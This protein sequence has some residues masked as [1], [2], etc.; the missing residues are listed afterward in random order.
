MK[1]DLQINSKCPLISC[2]MPT[3]GRP[4]Y[5]PEAVA[6]FLQQDY[7]NKELI[8]LNDCPGQTYTGDQPGVR[9]VNVPDRF[10]T[11]GE[12]RNASIE[13]AQGE[14]IAVWDD[15]DISLPWRLSLS[16][17]EMVR[18]QTPFYRPAEFLA[19]WGEKDLHDN[20]A[21]PDWVSHGP[22]TFTKHLWEQAGKYPPQNV[23][24]DSVL[25]TAFGRVLG[26][27]FPTH[28]I[29]RTDRFYVV[30][31]SSQY[32]HMSIDGGREPLDLKHGLLS[33]EPQTVQDEVLKMA[34][35]LQI[36]RHGIHS[37]EAI[38]RPTAD[39][40][41]PIISICVSL[42]NRSRIL[43]DG[44]LLDFFPR[45]VRAISDLAEVVGP[46][47][48]IVADFHSDDW[49]LSQ[50]LVS[51]GNLSVKIVHVDGDFS[52]GLGLNVAARHATCD[53]LFLTDADVLVL[54][55]ALKR[56]LSSIE[57]GV[58][59]FPM[60]RHLDIEGNPQGF[61]DFTH[62]LSFL[63]RDLMEQSGGIPEF[64]S[65]G[66][67]DNFFYE[68]VHSLTIVER[69]RDDGLL[70]QWHDESSRHEHYIHPRKHDYELHVNRTTAD[71]LAVFTVD[72]P[73]WVGES[74][75]IVLW[76]D[77]RFERPG[78][79]SGTFEY[80]PDVRLQLNWSRWPAEILQWNNDQGC[81][82]DSD[83]GI[84]AWP[85]DIAG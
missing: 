45:T 3:F 11:L 53:R 81:F 50:W 84:A 36:L 41:Q 7:P 80:E 26:V 20:H 40:F 30:R 6:C 56:G 10:Q 42:K 49:P 24:E 44:R 38:S 79:D 8:V 29:A 51:A 39:P 12:K 78:G 63:T 83:R 66:G 37:P 18:L 67:E 9:I 73:D 48:L 64:F 25:C 57:R 28:P 15:D 76:K 72:H 23:G 27:D 16:W 59:R 31:C 69:E 19:Y 54:P 60:F 14:I 21:V 13:M 17:Q 75:K 65:W 33:I 4:A 58:V 2:V 70:H 47:E 1:V 22:V 62:G 52:R 61:D 82:Q 55:E 43:H 74:R 5:V 68:K 46:I 77:G 71:P 85:L 35:D 34:C 32:Q